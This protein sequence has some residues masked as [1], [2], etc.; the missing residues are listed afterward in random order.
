MVCPFDM[1]VTQVAT[2]EIFYETTLKHGQ[3][4]FNWV[5]PRTGVDIVCL[6]DE[7]PAYANRG[8]DEW[9]VTLQIQALKGF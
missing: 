3:L 6:I 4:P 2:F 8:G 9:R 1:D 5:H 7:D